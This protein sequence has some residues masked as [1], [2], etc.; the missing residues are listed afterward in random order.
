MKGRRTYSCCF[1]GCCFHD[2]FSIARSTCAIAIKLLFFFHTLCQHPRGAFIFFPVFPWPFISLL[3]TSSSFFF[4]FLLFHF[5]FFV[6]LI[7][8]HLYF[9]YHSYILHVYFL[10]L[11]SFFFSFI[12]GQRKTCIL[13]D[14]KKKKN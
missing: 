1:V 7:F 2:L 14:Q 12:F 13:Y 11:F 10:F 4:L 3:S 8:F 5:F 6:L 9:F